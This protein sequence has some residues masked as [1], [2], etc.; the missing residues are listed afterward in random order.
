[1]WAEAL[2]PFSTQAVVIDHHPNGGSVPECR[3]RFLSI[4]LLRDAEPQ[5][6]VFPAR[7]AGCVWRGQQLD[8][9]AL[10]FDCRNKVS[11]VLTADEACWRAPCP[12]GASKHETAHEMAGTD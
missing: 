10:G 9:N 7:A 8:G 11:G 2:F 1:M 6:I 12:Q 3:D 4:L 5:G